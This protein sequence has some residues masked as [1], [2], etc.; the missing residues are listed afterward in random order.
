[1]QGDQWS[2]GA[3]I[4]QRT[5]IDQNLSGRP[6]RAVGVGILIRTVHLTG[7]IGRRPGNEIGRP[8]AAHVAHC[9]GV[10]R[11][12][13]RFVTVYG[14]SGRQRDGP[15]RPCGQ[16][17]QGAGESQVGHGGS[18]HGVPHGSRK[19]RPIASKSDPNTMWQVLQGDRSG[20]GCRPLV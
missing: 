12:Q 3:W 6:G 2:A 9:D 19:I 1:M 16:G 17:Q 7:V 15:R 10:S 14:E 5:L 20:I 18:C 4:R 8:I 13:L 11:P